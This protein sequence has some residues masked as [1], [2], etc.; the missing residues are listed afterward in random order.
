MTGLEPVT[1]SLPR[2][3]STT[4]LHRHA[5]EESGRRVSNP[6]P[7]AWKAVALPVELLPQFSRRTPS[8]TEHFIV[9]LICKAIIFVIPQEPNH[10]EKLFLIFYI[11]NNKQ[12]ILL[13]FL[14]SYVPYWLNGIPSVGREGFEPSKS[15]DNGFT[16]RPIWPLWHP[17]L[18]ATIYSKRFDSW[19]R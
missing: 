11:N 9:L 16:V 19:F 13:P 6:Q 7:T 8:S 3:Y 10:F 12:V 5:Y 1:P 17:P 4:E 14:I 18:Y 2:K 15:D